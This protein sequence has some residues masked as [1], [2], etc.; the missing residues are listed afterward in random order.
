MT[1][2]LREI[3]D[4]FEACGSLLRARSKVKDDGKWLAQ[5]KKDESL[6]VSV[7]GIPPEQGNET[8]ELVRPF[9]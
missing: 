8:V 9:R 7:N 2:A 5:V 6:M 4:W 3:L 1:R